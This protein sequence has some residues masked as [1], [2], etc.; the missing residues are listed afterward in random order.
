MSDFKK[1]TVNLPTE[2]VDFLQQLAAKEKVSVVDV[3]RRAIN[4]EKF[5]TD[6]EAAN[7]KILVEDGTRIREVIRR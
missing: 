6:N 7:R 4:S 5:F 1:I 3:L 2:Q